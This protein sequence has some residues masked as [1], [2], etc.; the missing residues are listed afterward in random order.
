MEHEKKLAFADLSQCMQP[1]QGT[2]HNYGRELWR[3]RAHSLEVEEHGAGDEEGDEAEGVT[4][5]VNDLGVVRVAAGVHERGVLA[6]AVV[7]WRNYLESRLVDAKLYGK[8]A[9]SFSQ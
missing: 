4:A 2:R 5:H 7:V 6:V 8:G 3:M 9:A 1:S